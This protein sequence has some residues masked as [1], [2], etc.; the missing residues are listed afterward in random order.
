MAA[1]L[2]TVV[3]YDGGTAV[4]SARL[5][6]LSPAIRSL[7]AAGP[8]AH[9]V[10]RAADGSPH[11]SVAW[12]GVDGD[13]LVI[14]TLDHLPEASRT[15]GATHTSR[16]RSS[17]AAG[18]RSSSTTPWSSRAALGSPRAGRP[19]SSPRWREPTSAPTSSSADA[20][21]PARLRDPDHRRS[22]LGHRAGEPR[23]LIRDP[24]P[25]ALR[26][27]GMPAHARRQAEVIRSA[28]V[29]ATIAASSPTPN[30]VEDLRVRRKCVPTK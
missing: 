10:T 17:P 19:R 24:R 12:I 3:G 20:E 1:A 21:P 16:S 14:A 29:R 30:S 28:I 2:R 23:R 25:A 9:V 13:E 26:P 22:S 27:R 8:P 4:R 7:V 15:S 5:A 6:G 11:V 18:T